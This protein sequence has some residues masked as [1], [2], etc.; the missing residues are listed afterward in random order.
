M[1]F[2]GRFIVLAILFANTSYADTSRPAV[3]IIGDSIS[4]GYLPRVQKLLH[5]KFR[6]SHACGNPKQFNCNNGQ[7]I[8]ILTHLKSYFASGDPDIITFNSGIHDMSKSLTA[9]KMPCA[10]APERV[11]PERYFQNLSKIADYL[12]DHAKTV[13]W[14]DTTTLPSSLCAASHLDQY[15]SIGEKVAHAHGFYILRIDSKF[16]DKG[17]IHFTEE[18]Y[19]TLGSQVA[20]CITVAWKS[21]ETKQCFRN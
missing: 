18:G 20:E 19:E 6:V 13:I 16:H 10:T 15:N 14:V 11:P 12:K 9:L 7:T 5:E 21:T 8:A 1:K 4:K 2:I 17:G 3:K